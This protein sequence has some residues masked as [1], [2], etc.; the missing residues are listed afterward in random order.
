M[1][2]VIFL[3]VMLSICS[4]VS[5]GLNDK[6]SMDFRDIDVREAFKLIAEKA[7]LGVA[8]EKSV[9]GNINISLKDVTIREALDIVAQ[10]SGFAWIQMRGTILL[11]DERRLGNEVKV[12]SLKQIDAE[13]AAKILSIS[14]SGDIKIASSYHNNSVVLNGSRNAIDTAIQIISHIDRPGK[15]IKASIKIMN[16]DQLLEK[17]DF[18]AKAGEK[19][20]FSEHLK[21]NPVKEGKKKKRSVVSLSCDLEIGGISSEGVLDAA[22]GLTVKKSDKA[23]GNETVRKYTGQFQAEK[24]KTLPVLTSS[25]FDAIKVI[26]TWEK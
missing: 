3:I 17:F 25:Q 15:Y 14:I 21:F 18:S 2:K 5:A 16:G 13:E 4:M 19:I 6:I 9:R 24:G 8:T 7:G 11:T 1:K 12:I 22:I 23:S 26:F 20:K 10:A